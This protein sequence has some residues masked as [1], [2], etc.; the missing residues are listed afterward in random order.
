[1]TETSCVISTMDEGDYFTGHVGSPSPACGEFSW[2][3][4]LLY[5]CVPS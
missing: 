2:L 5:L 4:E 3:I 1:M